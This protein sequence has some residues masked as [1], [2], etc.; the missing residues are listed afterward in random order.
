MVG[1]VSPGHRRGCGALA[2]ALCGGLAGPA[3]A[4]TA[5]EAEAPSFDRPGIAFSTQTLPRGAFAWEQGLPDVERDRDGGARSTRYAAATLLRLGLA[6]RLELQLSASPYVH[7]REREDGQRRSRHG[8]GDTGL[9]L[10]L[11]LPSAHERFS[12]AVLAGATAD[13]ARRGLGNGATVYTLGTT[14][15]YDFDDRVS[16]AL[17]FN[18]D[19]SDGRDTW[20]WSP[21]LGLALSERLGA[22]VEAGLSRSQ[23]ESATAVAGAGLT[24]M[25][26][27]RVQLDA[28][29]DRGLDARSPDWQGGVG[30]SFYFD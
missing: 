26:T 15:G 27:P 13:S 17:Y 30:V 6:D 5:D 10:K 7:L 3:A 20:T 16:G 23:G 24:W 4:A 11:A 2:L 9:A 1:A 28:S 21:S 12:W 19:R 18:L 8:A 14:L 25:A 22:Y 29:F